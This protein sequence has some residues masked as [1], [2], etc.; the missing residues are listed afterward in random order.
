MRRLKALAST[1]YAPLGPVIKLLDY[2][3]PTHCTV[4]AHKASL[5][6]GDTGGDP[7][8]HMTELAVPVTWIHP[9]SAAIPAHL[10]S[11]IRPFIAEGTGDT[12]GSEKNPR[13]CFKDWAIPAPVLDSVQR[14]RKVRTEIV[15]GLS[16]DAMSAP[17]IADPVP[18]GHPWAA[19]LSHPFYH[20]VV[21]ICAIEIG[22]TDSYL[23]FV[24]K[25]APEFGTARFPHIADVL[26][27]NRDAFDIV[28]SGISDPVVRDLIQRASQHIQPT[29]A[30]QDIAVNPAKSAAH[31]MPSLP[32]TPV[33]MRGKQSAVSPGIPSWA[34]V[35]SVSFVINLESRA[36]AMDVGI[37]TFRAV[38]ASET[39][40]ADSVEVDYRLWIVF[41]PK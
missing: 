22:T 27:G 31:K 33:K 1:V 41:G 21:Q 36:D 6:G 5:G 4:I 7:L 26:A 39:L 3:V 10:K 11:R 38:V 8:L 25:N 32:A 37:R 29:P 13:A 14:Y 18:G 12:F 34:C 40:S 24:A 19:A 20:R 28:P 9:D 2:F 15:G 23:G 30:S 35:R 17:S 16:R